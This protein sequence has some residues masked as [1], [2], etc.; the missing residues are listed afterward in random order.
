[1]PAHLKNISVNAKLA[2]HRKETER[3]EK[4]RAKN[5]ANTDKI[6]DMVDQ[7]VATL[8]SFLGK[9][10]VVAADMVADAKTYLDTESPVHAVPDEPVARPASG[11]GGNFNVKS[12]AERTYN[13]ASYAEA[14][15]M[16]E[17]DLRSLGFKK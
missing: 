15:T 1:M 10:K 17:N 9:A 6:D 3:L 11:K 16:L 2:F 4:E 8:R 5:M 12:I 7:G 13:A 14:E